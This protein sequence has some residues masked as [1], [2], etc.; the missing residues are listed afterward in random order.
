MIAQYL[1]ASPEYAEAI[2]LRDRVLRQPLGRNIID[3]PLEEEHD[4]VH[5]GAYVQGVLVAT[6][7]LQHMPDDALKLR[8]MAVAPEY[9]GQKWGKALVRACEAFAKTQG[10]S[11]LYCHA[12]DSALDFYK[13]CQWQ[14]VGEGFEEVGIPHHLMLAPAY[15]PKE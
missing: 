10:S 1:F 2:H 15:R 13:S 11:K 8:Q 5:L 3:D 7:S 14:V 12:R 4:Q 6:V 9:Q